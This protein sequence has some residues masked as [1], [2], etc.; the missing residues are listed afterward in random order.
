MKVTFVHHSCFVVE[1]EKQI[2]VFDY[3]KD[4]DL[5]GCHFGGVLPEFDRE[6]ELYFFASHKHQDH[7]DLEILKLARQYPDIHYILSKDIRLGSSYLLRHGIPL[8]VLER[9]IFVKPDAHYTVGAVEIETLR[10]T[11][12]GVAF[13]LEVEQ[14]QIYHAG[15]LHSWTFEGSSDLL[16]GK[17]ERDYKE[18]VS[19]LE[20]KHLAVAFVVLDGRLGRYTNDGLDYFLKHS[21]ADVVFPMHMWQQYQVIP[22]YKKRCSNAAYTQHVMDVTEENQVFEL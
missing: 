11:D 6:K 1:L 5:H 10:S 7:F 14:K 3:F 20:G 17:M 2:L 15:D 16:N 18:A 21:N 13:L 8:S 4:G 12:A 22:E 19:R 9:I